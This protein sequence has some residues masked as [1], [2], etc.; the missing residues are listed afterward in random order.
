MSCYCAE[1]SYLLAVQATWEQHQGNRD[2]A[3]RL[4]NSARE[5]AGQWS[6]NQFSIRA[7]A[8]LYGLY[9]SWVAPFDTSLS[10]LGDALRESIALRDYEFAGLAVNWFASN[11]VLRG[12]DL[13]SLG[14]R[15]SL[16][17]DQLSDAQ[18]TQF[19]SDVQALIAQTVD[20]LP[21][22]SDFIEKII[23]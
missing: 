1:I 20:P 4:A 2:R 16:H 9:D 22:H 10:M 23:G 21:S 17:V 15:L 8:T 3:Q 5:L 13:T 14:R 19:M 18:L 6:N 7:R 11:A 12:M